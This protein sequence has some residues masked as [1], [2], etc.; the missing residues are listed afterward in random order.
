MSD[1]LQFVVGRAEGLFRT[2]TTKLKW[3]RT[4]PPPA[5][6]LL[7]CAPNDTQDLLLFP[8]PAKYASD[9]NI[10]PRL[11]DGAGR[12]RHTTASTQISPPG[13]R[14]PVTVI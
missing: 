4:I 8:A 10:C 9:S 3:C 5:F 1:T 14:P 2:I 11:R 7:E 12:Y 6:P 13:Q